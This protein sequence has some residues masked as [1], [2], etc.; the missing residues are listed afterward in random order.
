[1][2]HITCQGF[3]TCKAL[4]GNQLGNSLGINTSSRRKEQADSRFG[5]LHISAFLASQFRLNAHRAKCL[6]EL[7]ASAQKL[8]QLLSSPTLSTARKASWGISTRPIRFIRF[9]PSFCFSRSFRLREMS[10]P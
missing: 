9:L 5:D 2:S 10:P 3:S 4:N 7:P 8:G 1:M 6:F